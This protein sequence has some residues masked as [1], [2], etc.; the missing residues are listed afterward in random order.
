MEFCN[1]DEQLDRNKQRSWNLVK[2][3]TIARRVGYML[4]SNRKLFNSNDVNLKAIGSP[5]F[6][7]A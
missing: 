5:V 6:N 2:Y 7:S 1:D 4:P 3:Q